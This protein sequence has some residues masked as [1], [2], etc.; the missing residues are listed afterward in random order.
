[1]SLI[2]HQT[3]GKNYWHI[4]LVAFH[5]G[6][7]LLIDPAVPRVRAEGLDGIRKQIEDTLRR[8]PHRPRIHVLTYSLSR[9]DSV[10]KP[11]K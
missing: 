8:A 6:E 2:E 4:C 5:N 1:M 3:A 7:L 9:E 10:E 11:E